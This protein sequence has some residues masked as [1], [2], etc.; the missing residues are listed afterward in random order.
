MYQLRKILRKWF[1]SN[2][3]RYDAQCNHQCAFG[4]RGSSRNLK[5]SNRWNPTVCGKCWRASNLCL[6]KGA[7]GERKP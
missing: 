6:V 3:S 2:F 7:A 4:V 1:R 5:C